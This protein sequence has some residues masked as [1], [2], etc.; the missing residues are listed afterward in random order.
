MK[1]SR[2]VVGK[3]RTVAE[4]ET[5][6]NKEY[7]EI[8]VA[9]EDEKEITDAKNWAKSLIDGWLGLPVE[10][11]VPSQTPAKPAPIAAPKIPE[12]DSEDLM[13]HEGWKNRRN[14]DGTY[15]KGSLAW[16]WEFADKF[17]PETIEVLQRGKDLV[18]DQY[19]FSLSEN[20]RLVNVKKQK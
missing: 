5:E 9:I 3:G 7:F 4:G 14:D 19:T 12:F 13:K 16:G 1:V 6:W 2:I 10:G 18:I 20:G 11:A 15:Q 17:K 8:E